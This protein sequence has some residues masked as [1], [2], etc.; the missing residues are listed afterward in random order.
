MDLIQRQTAIFFLPLSM[1]AIKSHYGE[2]SVNSETLAP[3]SP[4]AQ[5]GASWN[6]RQL[7]INPQTFN[8]TDNKLVQK[9]LTKGGHL[10]QY[11]GE[12]LTTIALSGTTGSAGIEGINI[13]RDIYRHEQIHYRKVL[14]DRKRDMAIAAKKAAEEAEKQ[15]YEGDAGGFFAGAADALAKNAG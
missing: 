12:D 11:W 7:Y 13:L 8:I 1:D 5:R 2:Y 10:V 3:E 15:V 6:K 4:A 9:Q 14:A